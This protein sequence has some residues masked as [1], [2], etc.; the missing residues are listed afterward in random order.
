MLKKNTV[1]LIAGLI[2]AIL[3]L[4][5][6]FSVISSLFYV[7]GSAVSSVSS[8]KSQLSSLEKQGK[9]LE[10]EVASAKESLKSASDKKSMIDQQ[11]GVTQSEIDTTQSL[12]TKLDQDIETKT[13]ELNKAQE[14]LDDQNDLYK[15]RVRVMYENGNVSYLDVLLSAENFSDMLSRLEIIQQIMVYDQ[16]LVNEY[17]ALK[18]QVAEDKAT[19][20]NDRTDQ[21]SYM[22]NLQQKKSQLNEQLAESQAVYNSLNENLKAKQ[23]EAEKVENEKDQ[24]SKEV[25]EL[26]KASSSSSG[27]SSSGSSSYNGS[28]TWP[29][30]GYHTITD[31]FGYRVHPITGKYKLH[32]GTD[33][34]A[35]AGTTIVAAAGGTVVK[36]CMTTAYGNYVV[37]NHG[38]GVITAYGHMTKRCVSKGDTVTAGE[39]IGT[40]GSTG[41]ST[42]NHLHFEVMINGSYTNPMQYF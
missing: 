2:A 36:S 12:I 6:L 15:E 24:I 4:A 18:D 1:K 16:K 42:G 38:N 26:S 5:L 25:E 35:P 22:S 30:P 39:K 8:M 20:E 19:L 14:K 11:I 7:Q 32:T 28:F 13:T 3:V 21:Q 23:K 9:Q 41:W 29:L 17:T 37:I 31:P 40:V 10:K 33:I 27:S 34:A